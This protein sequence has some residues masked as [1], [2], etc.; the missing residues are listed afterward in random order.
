[1]KEKTKRSLIKNSG[2]VALEYALVMVIMAMVA[3]LLWIF[4]QWGLAEQTFY[5]SYTEV[6]TMGLEQTVSNPFP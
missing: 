4:Y 3:S 1:M 6:R 2:Q 5:G